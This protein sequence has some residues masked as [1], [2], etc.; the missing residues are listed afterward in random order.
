MKT[1]REEANA[2]VLEMARRILTDERDP[3]LPTKSEAD[4]LLDWLE[5]NE[6]HPVS[7]RERFGG[8]GGWTIWWNVVERGKSISGHPVGN[9]R[10]AI[11]EAM[12][13]HKKATAVVV[14]RGDEG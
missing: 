12:K 11:R 2:A 8:D 3:R 5:A 14:Q 7:H 10:E 6:A 9:A 13:R 4:E 1:E